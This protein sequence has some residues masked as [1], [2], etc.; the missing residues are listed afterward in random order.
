[1]GEVNKELLEKL[2]KEMKESPIKILSVEES[3][4]KIITQKKSL[5]RFGDGELDI[6]LGKS[7]GFQ[8]STPEIAKRLEDVL[9]AKQDFCFVG[10]PDAIN[11]FDNITE[12]SKEFWVDNM[13]RVRS[14]WLK[15]LDSEKEY[16]T[17]NL[18]RLYI[19]YKDKS[20]CEKNFTKLKSIWKNRDIV[21]CE[22]AQTR[23]GVG[24]DI[25]E[26]AK[27]VKRIICPAENSF[28]KYD[29]IIETMKQFDKN[30]LF[31]IALG[32]TATLLA[33]EMAKCGY[34]ALDVGHFDIEYEWFL[35][36]A[37][38]KEKIEN[39]YVYEV[40][41]GNKTENVEDKEYLAQIVKIIE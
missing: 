41:N 30:H 18:T 9:T 22:G 31:L 24:N 25:L 7:L 36:H 6:I 3:L 39:K 12:E 37:D 16:L 19:R 23:V 8:R 5:C 21:I 20:Q 32:P 33:F 38:K 17:A 10:V 11:N 27:S 1:M 29:K 40:D 28:D 14:V 13:A 2:L 34:Q 15:Y 26:G 4:D 35:R